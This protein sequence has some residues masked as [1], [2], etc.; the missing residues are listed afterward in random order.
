MKRC[1]SIDGDTDETPSKRIMNMACRRTLHE[2][3]PGFAWD[4]IAASAPLEVI[5]ISP[6]FM[7]QWQIS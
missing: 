3:S 5:L 2:D 4:N 6:S 1:E 7:H